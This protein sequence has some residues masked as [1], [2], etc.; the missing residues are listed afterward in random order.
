MLIYF[1]RGG[2]PWEQLN[3]PGPE[4]REDPI[5]E[6]KLGMSPEVLCQDLPRE[7]VTYMRHVRDRKEAL[8]H[9][10]A[11]RNAFRRLFVRSGFEYDHVF[12]WTVL[13]FHE[14][15]AQGPVV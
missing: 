10:A 13:K 3:A 7:F 1:L 4:E 15:L 6:M 2:L 11:L 5:L 8:P 14:H 12:D 9:Y